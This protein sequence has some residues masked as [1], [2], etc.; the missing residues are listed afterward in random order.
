MRSSP[1]KSLPISQDLRHSTRHG[2]ARHSAHVEWPG[3]NGPNVTARIE[4]DRSDTCDISC[5]LN[6]FSM[7]Q[8]SDAIPFHFYFHLYILIYLDIS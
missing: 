2:T 4:A 1:S 7:F 5:C 3:P 6:S 8:V